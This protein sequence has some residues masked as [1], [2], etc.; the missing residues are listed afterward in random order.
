M[1]KVSAA[2]AVIDNKNQIVGS[3]SPS[4]IINTVFGGIKHSN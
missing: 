2:V 1:K 3:I 4:K